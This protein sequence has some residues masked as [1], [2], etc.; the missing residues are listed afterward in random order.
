LPSLLRN[1]LEEFGITRDPQKTASKKRGAGK[2]KG[3]SVAE[4]DTLGDAR[5]L[6][7]IIKSKEEQMK[8]AAKDL[9]FELAAIL[10]DEIR[11]LQA[12]L[13][14]KA[15]AKTKTVPQRLSQN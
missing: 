6:D 11:E 1:L 7:Q 13:T 4:L 12:R 10:R 9:E 15:K 14:T 8:Q 5:P 2:A 3:Q